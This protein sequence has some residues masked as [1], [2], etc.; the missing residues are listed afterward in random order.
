V[1]IDQPPEPADDLAR[2]GDPVP[3][4]PVLEHPAPGAG[5]MEPA[6]PRTRHEHAD[7]PPSPGEPSDPTEESPSNELDS[8]DPGGPDSPGDSPANGEACGN[9]EKLPE[10]Q[11][12]P[13]DPN[14]DDNGTQPEGP[15]DDPPDPKPAEK[16]EA[17]QDEES[18]Q[19]TPD[20]IPSTD[21]PHPL[22]GKEWAE[23]LTEVRDGLGQ[24]RR[25]GLI[26]TRLH[27]ING[28]GEVWTEDRDRL[29]DSILEDLY[30]KASDVPC[31]FKSIIAGGLGGAG[32]T[33]VLT[34]QAGID[35][36]QYMMIN[37]DLIKGEMARRGMIL[38]IDALSPMEASE[39][40]H[41]ESS[42][43]ANQLA[44]RAEA[45]GKNMIWDITM[46][47]QGSTTKR[48]NELSTAG[49]TRIDGIFVNIPV[50]TSLRRVESRHQEDHEQYLVGEGLGGRYVPPQ[51]IETQRDPDWDSKNRKI[52]DHVKARFND[53]SIYDNSV[54]GRRAVLIESSSSRDAS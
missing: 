35:L 16:P 2:E 29:H 48:I 27:T 8:P 41:E 36:S 4:E 54:D 28:S 50:G 13:P 1:R 38:E 10:S 3:D 17:P 22:T 21:P 49:Y 20:A 32:K 44:L 42:Y 51:V 31:G 11:E 47:R 53:W 9:R 15:L 30:A 26:S 24:A 25:E 18:S 19:P 39:L 34:Q 23:H 5:D 52:F 12:L 6:E 7:P 40:V 43:L 33:T 45:D 37:P 46:S 14:V